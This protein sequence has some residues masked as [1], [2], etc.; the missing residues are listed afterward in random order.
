[1][2]YGSLPIGIVAIA[3]GLLANAAPAQA[4]IET[5]VSGRG[6]DAGTCPIA[7]PCRTF[8]YAHGQ[9]S[10]GGAINVLAAGSFGPLTISKSISIV[11]DG[12][13]ALITA[14]NSGA[15]II[16]QAN[17]GNVVSLRGLTI[18]VSG[19]KGISFVSGAALH[20]QNSVIRR[21][22]NGIVFA[23]ATGASELHVSDSVIASTALAGIYVNPTGTGGAKVVLNRVRVGGS[24][25]AFDGSVTTGSIKATVS[26]SVIA[27]TSGSGILAVE[28]GSGT[29]NVMVDHTVSA[30]NSTGIKAQGAG[31]TIRIGDSTVAGNATGLETGGGGTIASYGNNKVNGNGNDGAPTSPIAMK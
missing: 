2:R 6:T 25:V 31:A 1:M 21:A 16:V 30:N 12:V 10:A 8:A 23:P 27:G 11:A 13:E 18:E 7:S 26:H 20:V 3:C 17:P 28:S 9:T 14:S 15:A 29:T 5:W 24:G 19:A 22:V 4:A